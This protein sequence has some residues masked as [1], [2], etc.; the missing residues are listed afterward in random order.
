MPYS[1]DVE[2]AEAGVEGA[3]IPGGVGLAAGLLLAGSIGGTLGAFVFGWAGYAFAARK[4]RRQ[5]NERVERARR[6]LA[7]TELRRQGLTPP[8]EW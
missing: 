2:I 5:I 1:A 4:C 6:S 7:R 3:I 8:P